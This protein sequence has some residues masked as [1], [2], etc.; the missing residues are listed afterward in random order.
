VNGRCA[1][2]A[3]VAYLAPNGG[4]DQCTQTAPCND[5]IV[6]EN[7]MKPIIK[8]S[9]TITNTAALE[10]EARATT[11][12]AEPGAAITRSNAG[13]IIEISNNGTELAIYGLR[14]FGGLGGN[15]SNGILFVGQSDAKLTLDRVLIE[16]NDGSGVR[17]PDGGNV[18]ITRSVIANNTGSQGILMSM[19]TFSITN[20]LIVGNG[21]TNIPTGGAF[22]NPIGSSTFEFNTVAD[23]V[24][25]GGTS[26]FRGVTCTGDFPISNNII[27]GNEVSSCD[28]T[29]SF[30]SPGDMVAGTGNAMGDPMFKSIAT[31][32]GPT[33]YRLM[34]NSP[35]KDIAD[36]NATLTTDIDGNMRPIDGRSD[37]GA[38]EVAP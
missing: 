5:A 15:T 33:F 6:A 25:M 32:S 8:V 2:E 31:P 28:V 11:I 34:P 36:S 37:M 10:F 27:V 26:S 20:T 30:F 38:D 22:L 7:T 12:Y 21:R 29:Y 19:N 24:S 1:D 14:I 35:A 18:T 4:G 23:N 16:N 3:N 13:N 9:G 17:A